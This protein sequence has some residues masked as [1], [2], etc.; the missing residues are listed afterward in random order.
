M[1]ISTAG[2]RS[3]VTQ[4][5]ARIQAMKTLG[6]DVAVIGPAAYDDNSILSGAKQDG[7]IVFTAGIPVNRPTSISA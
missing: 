1:Q 4:Q 5:F 3:N 7:N 2:G 6:L